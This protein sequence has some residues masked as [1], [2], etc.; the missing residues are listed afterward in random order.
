[1]TFWLAASD[2]RRISVWNSKWT[3]DMLQMV[4]WITFPAPLE[5]NKLAVSL[6]HPPSLAKFEYSR[7]SQTTKNLVYVGYGLQKQVIVYN[8]VKKQIVRTMDLSEW[9]QCMCLSNKLHLMAFGTK[10]R[11]LQLKDY[12]QS[13]FQDYSHHSDT[14][15]SVCF[16]NDDKKLISTAYNEIFIWDVN[17]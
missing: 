3:E 7:D 15:S 5:S 14:V 4:D 17:V 9:P 13:S 12:S 6:K 11:L 10:S 1:M 16:S 2:D 8:F